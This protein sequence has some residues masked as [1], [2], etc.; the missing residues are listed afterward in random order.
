M[1]TS[2]ICA[3][4]N[5][6]MVKM[7]QRKE[8]PVPFV[9]RQAGD[10]RGLELSRGG[11]LREEVGGAQRPWVSSSDLPALLFASLGG[12]LVSVQLNCERS[13]A[14]AVFSPPLT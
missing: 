13:G 11:R 9:T 5:Y 7:N 3:T 4:D 2:F 12:A 6:F 10:E 1:T 14:G 8:M